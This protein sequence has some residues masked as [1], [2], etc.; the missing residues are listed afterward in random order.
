MRPATPRLRPARLALLLLAAAA[1]APG[2][3]LLTEFVA[4]NKNGLRDEDGD[5]SDWVE[6]YNDGAAAVDLSGWSL[7]DD[8]LAPD[9]WLFPAVT[10]EPGG[11]LVVFA[12]DK[13]RALAG[14]PLHA[15]FKLAASGGYLGL[16]Q[17][18]GA[19]VHEYNPY[20]AQY[21]DK[22]Y[23]V[24][25]SVA[26][27]QLVGPA[28]SLRW[29]VPTSPVPA[30]STWTT[31]FYNHTSWATGPSGVGFESS[32]PQWQLRVCFSNQS[33]PSL[34]QAEAVLVTPALQSRVE[35]ANHPVVNF[36]NTVSEGHYLP[37]SQPAFLTGADYDNYV[38]EATAVVTIPS[39]G[40]WT[41]CL[42]SDDG[43]AL[44]V[45]PPGGAY[46]TV[47]SHPDPRGMADSLGS[48]AFP[49]AGPYEIRAVVYEQGGG[50]GG[51][52]SAKPG[53]ASA[54]DPSFKLVGDTANGGLAV[55]SVSVGEGSTGYLAHVGCDVRTAMADA[56]PPKSSCYIRYPFTIPTDLT[57]LTMAVRYDDGFVAYLNGTEVARRNAPPGTPTN[58]STATADRPPLLAT[59][60][61]QIDLTASLG[62]LVSG[63]NNILAVHALNQAA[64]DGDLLL[65]AE[66]AQH[67]VTHGDVH[68][69][70]AATPAAFNTSTVYNRVAPVVASDGRQFCP[71][72]R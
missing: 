41:F 25:Q 48:H 50:S 7:T 37:D 49:A 54:W 65:Q 61:E 40:T 43:C 44:Q 55:T 32:V 57:S 13:D 4:S 20:P 64:S 19:L 42:G 38:V 6:L 46:T 18:G 31:R 1:A 36:N 5:A 62:L 9:K 70:Q 14:A 22:P 26:T 56:S 39:A 21:E 28:A 66:L 68:F 51:E 33:V 71:R 59:T 69:Y 3:V 12:S 10:L 27:T 23:G 52:V 45:R 67:T 47:L 53:S 72:P 2:D 63:T 29:F 11:F 15:S 60:P 8:P 17:P 30:D 24:Q 58:T 35:L 16:Y 34:A